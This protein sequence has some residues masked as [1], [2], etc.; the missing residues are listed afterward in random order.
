MD[1]V[2]PIGIYTRCRPMGVAVAGD[3]EESEHHSVTYAQHPWLEGR[4]L[5]A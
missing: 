5:S 2:K 1:V 4:G 3:M